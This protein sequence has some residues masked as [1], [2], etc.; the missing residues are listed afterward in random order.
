[1]PRHAA[2]CADHCALAHQP[3]GANAWARR[4]ATLRTRPATRPSARSYT[5]ATALL[6]AGPAAVYFL[7]DDS[8]A[9]GERREAG[10]APMGGAALGLQAA[11]TWQA[12]LAEGRHV[13]PCRVC[14]LQERAQ[15]DA[16]PPATAPPPVTPTITTP[17]V[18][19]QVVIALTCIAGGS[20]A[21]G[22]ASLLSTL[23]KS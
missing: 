4:A 7:P 17:A 16:R 11:W 23:Q 1:M 13:W 19:L 18:A 10:P 3:Q 14:C 20:A 15:P 21:W 9:L 5:V 2:L 6:V 12:R 8:A 22:G